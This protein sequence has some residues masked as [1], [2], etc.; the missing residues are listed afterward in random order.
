MYG[1]S[2]VVCSKVGFEL[3]AVSF[4]DLVIGDD[5]AAAPLLVDASQVLVLWVKDVVDE[6]EACLSESGSGQ[7][8]VLHALS[9]RLH[10]FLG[11]EH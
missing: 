9:R 10:A 5:E 2:N 4:V 11:E 6:L 1:E 7:P 8:A 3:L